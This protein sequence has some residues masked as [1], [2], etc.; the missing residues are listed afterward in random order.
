M[1]NKNDLKQNIR[2]AFAEIKY[3]GDWCLRGSN[4]GEEP[5]LVEDAFKGKKDWSTLSATFL[6]QAPEGFSSAL[7]FFSDE[8]FRFYLP[9]YLIADIDEKLESVDMLFHLL[10]GLDNQ[11]MTER[12]SPKRYGERRWFDEARHKYSM[13]NLRQCEAI[14]AYLYFKMEHRDTM[15]FEREQI[16]QALDNYWLAR[17]EGR[18]L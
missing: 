17:A 18:R 3:P 12:V 11:T 4:E 9:A 10:F 15:D 1:I 13:F 2:D 14:V 5:Y 6:D 8:A 7:A 16:R